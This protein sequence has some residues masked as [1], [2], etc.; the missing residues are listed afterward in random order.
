[1]QF[2]DD[3]ENNIPVLNEEI[4]KKLINLKNESVPK[5]TKD[6]TNSHAN[7]FKKFPKENKLSDVIE[8]IPVRFLAK[9]LQYFN[10]RKSDGTSYLS[11]NTLKR[12]RAGI[13][14]YL[15]S[16][17]VNRSVNIMK[18]REFHRANGV[19]KSLV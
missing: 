17:N 9:Y 18:D 4:A 14:R 8:N 12:I 11:P 5:S 15:T 10:L 2:D 1:M 16:S 19:L 13:Q 3:V 7:D 6:S